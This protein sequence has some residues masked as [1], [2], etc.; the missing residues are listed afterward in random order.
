MTIFTRICAALVP[1]LM[2]SGCLF[3]PGKFTSAMDIRKDGAFSFSYVGEIIVADPADKM[4]D[5]QTDSGD[6]ADTGKAQ[7]ASKPVSKDKQMAEKM[8]ALVD[9]LSKERGFRSVRYVGG[10]KLSVDY[11]I[12]GRLDHSFVFPFN[13]D[14]KAIIPFVA[15]EVRADG[16]VRMLA[17]GFGNDNEQSAAVPMGGLG[18]G[19]DGAKER[20][21]TFTLTTDAEIVSQNQEDGPTDTPQGKRIVWKITPLTRAA[22]MMVLKLAQ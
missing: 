4:P 19:D 18:G 3:T 1:L 8:R 12:N 11:R 13:I 2:L 5:A 6:A 22:P 16:K 15:V 10:T 20:D 21:G 14:A 17:P 7:P 9:T